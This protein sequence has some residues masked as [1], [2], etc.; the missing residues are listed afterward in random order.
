IVDGGGTGTVVTISSASAQVTLTGL[1]IRN[2]HAPYFGGGISNLGRLALVNSNVSGNSAGGCLCGN[3]S[4]GGGIY[5]G[6]TI[7]TNPRS[8]SGNTALGGGGVRGG[9]GGGNG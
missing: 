6:G 2:G 1:T 9:H 4:G 8:I 3:L 7:T 5:N